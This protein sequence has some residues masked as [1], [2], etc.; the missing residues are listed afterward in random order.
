MS[1]TTAESRNGRLS[2]PAEAQV[3]RAGRSRQ[4]AQRRARLLAPVRADDEQRHSV[5]VSTAQEIDQE[6]Y[7][8][9]VGPLQV[10]QDHDDRPRRGERAERLGEVRVQAKPRRAGPELGGLRIGF[11]SRQT[12]ERGLVERQDFAA[13]AEQP[14]RLGLPAL[15]AAIGDRLERPPHRFERRARRAVDAGGRRQA[16]ARERPR[17]PAGCLAGDLER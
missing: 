8:Q 7:R 14:I 15:A 5:H 12:G 11:L 13:R 2:E 6:A 4:L 10:V 9:L 3:G 17:V 1:P 16:L